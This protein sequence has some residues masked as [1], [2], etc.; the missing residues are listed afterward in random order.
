[1][2]YRLLVIGVMMGAYAWLCRRRESDGRAPALWHAGF[3]GLAAFSAG[4][5][6]MMS[7]QER[8]HY[9]LFAGLA[10]P[11]GEV[12]PAF[13]AGL[14]FTALGYRHGLSRLK[15]A[16]ARKSM[17]HEDL[18]WADTVF[19]SALMASLLMMFVVQ[20]FKIPS[21][22]MERT[23]LIGDQLFV[24]KFLY[25]FKLPFSD[26]RA[27]AVRPVR[28][29]DILVFRFPTEDVNAVNCGTKEYGND[30]IKRAIGLPGETVEVRAGRV[31]IDGKPLGAEPYAQWTGSYHQSRSERA[32]QLTPEQYQQI[33]QDRG[34]EEELQGVE[35]DYFGP[36][37]VPPHSFFMMG[38]NRDF[39]CDSRYWG[40]VPEKYVKGKAWFIYW[41]PTRL[42]PL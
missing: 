30:L 20:A 32:A 25:G 22:S 13:L 17:R 3:W 29:G 9:V 33:W 10:V 23:L 24:S 21:G 1:M 14:V 19:S 36:V 38:D 39:S 6:I 5:V 27:L 37:T 15:D 28:R 26:K 34:L 12:L 18:E 16:A 35:K 2:E 41:P 40:P 8:P 7:F 4:L 31:F 42:G 11:A